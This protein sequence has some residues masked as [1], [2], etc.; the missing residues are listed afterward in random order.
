VRRICPTAASASWF[1]TFALVLVVVGVAGSRVALVPVAVAGWIT[2]A[3][4]AT[5]STSSA[6]PAITS[7][8]A[9]IDTLAGVARRRRWCS[10]SSSAAPWGG[11]CAAPP[12]RAWGVA[13][14]V[15]SPGRAH[16]S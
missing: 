13:D 5:S 12:R 14:M 4:W 15:A 7:P 3:Y 6:D 10:P 8:R 2:A 16:A 1:A 11:R 9:L